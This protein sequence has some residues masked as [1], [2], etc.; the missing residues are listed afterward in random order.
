MG[1]WHYPAQY[2]P[3]QIK[4][5]ESRPHRVDLG[6]IEKNFSSRQARRI[7]NDECEEMVY[8]LLS[9]GHRK[10]GPAVASRYPNDVSRVN[11]WVRTHPLA[12][13]EMRAGFRRDKEASELPPKAGLYE[14]RLVKKQMH[15]AFA[16]QRRLNLESWQEKQLVHRQRVIASNAA[17]EATRTANKERLAAVREGRA[18]MFMLRDL[19]WK[20][21]KR[22][23]HAAI[24]HKI[25]VKENVRLLN[26]SRNEHKRIAR[27]ERAIKGFHASVM[28]ANCYTCVKG[29]YT[30]IFI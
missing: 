11:H 5:K 30:A 2:F 15:V 24:Q 3:V 8:D 1:M 21:E 28:G 6:T 25:E 29:I 26:A 4:D 22:V 20:A 12:V 14:K 27:L 18:L 13:E 10:L 17:Y 9:H 7:S 16:I 23:V 19:Q